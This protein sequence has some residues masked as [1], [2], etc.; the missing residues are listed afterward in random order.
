MQFVIGFTIWSVE[1]EFPRMY[2]PTSETYS[3]TWSRWSVPY[4]G[5]NPSIKWPLCDAQIELDEGISTED[6]LD[7]ALGHLMTVP[8]AVCCVNC[9]YG[10][11]SNCL[12]DTQYSSGR[13][14]C[15]GL[16]MYLNTILRFRTSTPIHILEQI[17]KFIITL[18]LFN[19]FSY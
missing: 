10:N 15:Q 18:H 14:V 1:S 5:H 12:C 13:E 2:T 16:Y 6:W 8:C 17:L 11:F 3:W 4:M 19:C 7:F 9:L